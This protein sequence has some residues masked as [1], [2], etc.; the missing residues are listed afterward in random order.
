[1]GENLLEIVS[2]HANRRLMRIEAHREI[3]DL[4]AGITPLKKQFCENWEWE[5]NLKKQLDS[6][7][8]SEAE[9]LRTIEICHLELEELDEAKIKENEDEE[10]FAEYA[11]LTNSEE[12]ARHAFE[13]YNSLIEGEHPAISLLQREQNTFS[14]LIK[15]D[16]SLKPFYEA[17]QSAL[18]ELKEVACSLRNYHANIEF[19]PDKIAEINERLKLIN[20]IKK[21]YGATTAEI[22]RYHEQTKQKL[23]ELQRS[24]LQIEELEKSLE[25]AELKSQALATELTQKRTAA[26]EKFE[27]AI[28]KQL[29]ALNMA[30]TGFYVSLIPS[31]RSLHG[32][33]TVEFFFAPNVGEKK[34]AIR[35]SASGGEL[36]RIMLAIQTLLA[37]KERIPTLVFDEIDANIGG[38]TATVI[39]EKLRE[40]GEIHQILCITHFP[41]VA[42][43]A[44]HHIQISKHEKQGRTHTK[45]VL[46]DAENRQKELSRMTGDINFSPAIPE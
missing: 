39:G 42:K 6:L 14:Q 7:K 4:F 34:I 5:C 30:K 12:L 9:R 23:Y 19:N 24:D 37:G 11:R 10:L 27:T 20:K 8:N 3:L 15:F 45:I 13:I 35:D 1:L 31:T 22:G 46:L 26:V 36:S 38:E 21:K 33:E 43:C 18:L 28:K 41:Q 44:E 29:K 25:K 17:Y 16:P 32:D 40:I 2:Q